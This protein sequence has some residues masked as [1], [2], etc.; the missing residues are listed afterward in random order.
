MRLHQISQLKMSNGK[1]HPRRL[2][3]PLRGGTD[4]INLYAE[5][6][7]GKGM[8]FFKFITK[9]TYVDTT[10]LADTQT[11]AVFKYIAVYVKD[12]AEVG[13]PRDEVSITGKKLQE[14]V[15][16]LQFAIN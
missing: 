6:N 3:I 8:K 4:C 2:L 7:D 15:Y 1:I 9:T 13:I 5:H 11:S 10:E 12:D 14:N 16:G